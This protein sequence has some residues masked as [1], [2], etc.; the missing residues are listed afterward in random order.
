ML[1]KVADNTYAFYRRLVIVNFPKMFD[2]STADPTLPEKLTAE[3]EL[4]GI[5][6]WALEGL[7]RLMENGFRFSYK[8]SVEE[9]REIYT[10]ASNPVKAFLDEE[11]VE[12]PEAWIVK[13]DLYEAYKDYVQRHKLQSPLSPVSF[14]INVQKYRK[15]KTERKNVGNERKRVF[16]G[17]ALRTKKKRKKR[18]ARALK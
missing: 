3:E 15:L 10:R 16:V 2:E 12:D 18:K 8:K 11:T 7:K 1:L 9:I 14:F 5:L 17:L 13:Q 6:N 4:S